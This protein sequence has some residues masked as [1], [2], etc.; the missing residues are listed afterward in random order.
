[1]HK[2]RKHGEVCKLNVNVVETAAEAGR[3]CG[4]D[5]GLKHRWRIS[6]LRFWKHCKLLGNERIV[7]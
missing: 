5:D 1:M 2:I 3:N 7:I 6:I 4:N